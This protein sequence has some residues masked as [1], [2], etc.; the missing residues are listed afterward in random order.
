MDV[1]ADL[2]RSKK[3]ITA[4]LGVAAVIGSE[5]FGVTLDV[6]SLASITLIIS[7]Y[8]LGQGIADN[9]K[10]RAKL[11]IKEKQRIDLDENS[12]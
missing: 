7:G 4:I 12:D 11:I 5:V 1:F 10:E 3:F 9:G 2:L 8:V 6:E